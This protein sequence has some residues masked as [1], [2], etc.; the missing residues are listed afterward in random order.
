[1]CR[2]IIPQIILRVYVSVVLIAGTIDSLTGQ[3]AVTAT[4]KRYQVNKIEFKGNHTF[5]SDVLKEVIQTRETPGAIS[6]FFYRT[7]GEKVGSK[8]EVFDVPMFIEDQQRLR[9][10][11]QSNGYFNSSISASTSSDS[12]GS[13]I[14]LLFSIEENKLS[15]IDSIFYSGIDSLPAEIK[16]KILVAPIIRKGVPYLS[17]KASSEIAR[18]LDYLWNSGYPAA[19]YD[20][21]KSG[22][23][24]FLSS[25]NFFIK[26][27]F[28]PGKRYTFGDISIHVDPPRKDI[29]NDLSIRQL[30]FQSGDIFSREKLIS[31]EGSLNRLGLFES[32]RIDHPSISDT[33]ASNIIPIDIYMRPMNRND[34]SPE[35]LVSDEGGFF[36][37]GI[38]LGF[39]NRN[40]FGD[41]RIFNAH[42]RIRTQDI[43]RWNFHNVFHGNGLRDI[44][45]KGIIELQFQILQPYFFTRTLSG[46]WTSTISAEKQEL[47]ILSILRNNIGL[48]KRFATYTYGFFDWT[49]ERVSPEIVQDTAK[50]QSVLKVLRHEDQPQFNS[51]LTITLQRDK[52]NDIFSPSTGFFNSISL[53]ESGVLPK[54]LPGIRAGLPFTQYY[55]VTLLGRWYQDLTRRRFNILA[56]KLKSGYQ[57]KYGES[58]YSSVQI[59]LN[60]RFFAGGSGSVRGW[61]ARELGAMPS[62]LIQFGGNFIFE[63]SVEMR[64]SHFKG[65]GKLWFLQL[66]NLLGVYFLD[67][68]NTWSDI[69]YFKPKQIAVAAGIGLRYETFFGPFRIDYGFRAY[70]PMAKTGNQTVF[71]KRFFGETLKNAVFT[72]G[73]GHAF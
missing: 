45:V 7:F 48:S 32:A 61:R 6:Q 39:I 35:L 59:P 57:N 10:F 18:I 36:N 43:Q 8:P 62:E 51:I 15:Y 28:V 11:Y 42:T 68:G 27:V 44:S 66:D 63:G 26:F 17:S 3:V 34:L 5:D 60:R 58:K 9:E 47:I 33:S 23:F 70:D 73:I 69:V 29:T 72:F 31:S 16:S 64:I 19:H 40:F 55:K 52:T 13:K 50:A 54:L 71:Q 41:A 1:M 38:G 24:K 22:A 14:D 67:F 12:L 20:A 4:D 46:N 2:F 53:E 49:L 25:D 37:L 21:D 65:F 56:W 30:D